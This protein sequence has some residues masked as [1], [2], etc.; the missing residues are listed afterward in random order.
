MSNFSPTGLVSSCRSR[1][2]TRTWA[3]SPRPP[4][5]VATLPLPAPRMFP[6]SYTPRSLLTSHLR[7]Y[8]PLFSPSPSPPLSQTS[9][10]LGYQ[11]ESPEPSPAPELNCR[12]ATPT[13]N[14]IRKKWCCSACDK[15]FR[16]KWECNRHIGVI[17]RRA[18]CLAC[19]GNLNGREDSLRRHYKKYCKGDVGN[20]KFEDVFIEVQRSSSQ[21]RKRTSW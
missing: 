10:T 21:V 15:P 8:L 18:K 5:L 3:T 7:N 4:L 13:F 6:L 17:G 12:A 1:A 20:I 11:Q 9:S 16:G 19:G 2:P 14:H